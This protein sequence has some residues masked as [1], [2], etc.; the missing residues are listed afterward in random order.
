MSESATETD[1]GGTGEVTDTSV[2]TT[3]GQGAEGTADAEDQAAEEA[4]HQLVQDDPDTLKA[5]VERW[6]RMAQRHERS[7]RDNSAAAKR[8]RDLEDANK[9]DLQKATEAQR[10]AELERDA[11]RAEHNRTTAAAAHDLDPGLAEFLGDGSQED[12]EARADQLSDIIA[13]VATKLAEQMI[14]Q[15]GGR[16]PGGARPG[17]PVESMRPGAA[18]AGSAATDANAMFRQILTGNG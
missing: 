16:P 14:Q 1:V 5:E 9:S 2:D 18:P 7:A 11:L 10:A 15:N 8:L 3:S 13:K 6:K 17:R 12:I 4:L